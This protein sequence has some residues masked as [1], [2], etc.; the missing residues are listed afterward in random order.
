V[1]AA[2][3]HRAIEAVWRIECARIIADLT[4]IVRDLGIAEELAQ[5]SLVAALEQWPASGVPDNPGA[6][7]VATAKH[8]AR[9]GPR[10]G[11]SGHDRTSVRHSG[12]AFDWNCQQHIIPRFNEEEI[13]DVLVPVEKQMQ[14]LE[15]KTRTLKRRSLGSA[16]RIQNAEQ[17]SMALVRLNNAVDQVMGSTIP[18]LRTPTGEKQWL[19]SR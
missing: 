19:R 6:W 14:E 2:D 18:Q 1:K 5:D 17:S 9:E 13:R 15:G 3:T 12:G 8:R 11:I 10:S 4:R 16:R 7:L